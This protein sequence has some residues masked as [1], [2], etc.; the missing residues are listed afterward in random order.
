M[1]RDIPYGAI[2]LAFQDLIRQLL[3]ESETALQTW[4]QQLLASLAGN[5]Q[6]IIDVIPE[7]EQIIGQQPP[8][9]EL[10]AT[11]AQNR[12]NLYFQKFIGVFTKQE[13]PLVLSLTIYS[14]QI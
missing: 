14:G 4:K 9:E 10:G 1:Q 11:E 13:H 3:S 6:L 7:L 2:A 12:F 5:G 8:V